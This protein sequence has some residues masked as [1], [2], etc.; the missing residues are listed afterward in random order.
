L[1]FT[2]YWVVGIP[3]AVS[4]VGSTATCCSKD[5][6]PFSKPALPPPPIGLTPSE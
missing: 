6:S 5:G 3:E 2:L 1:L 4:R